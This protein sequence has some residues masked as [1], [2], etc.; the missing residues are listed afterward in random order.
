MKRTVLRLIGLILLVG[1]LSGVLVGCSKGELA[2]L[3]AGNKGGWGGASHGFYDDDFDGWDYDDDY[4]D[5]D[6]DYYEDLKFQ[7]SLYG[8]D[9]GEAAVSVRSSYC[10]DKNLVIPQTYTDYADETYRV[11]KDYYVGFG[12]LPAETVTLPEGFREIEIGFSGCPNLTKICL[13]STITKIGE[14]AITNCPNLKTIE[15]NGTKAQWNAVEKDEYW[16]YMASSL[17]VSCKDGTV[18]VPSW[19]ASH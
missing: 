10:T 11:V 8:C 15:F 14:Y 7:F 3:Y 6:D 12:G 2:F 1:L 16:N 18:T 4:D 9:D 5:Y 13:P 17:T 19:S